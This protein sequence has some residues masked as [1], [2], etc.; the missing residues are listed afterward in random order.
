MDKDALFRPRVDEDD[1]EIP[2]VGTVRVRGLTRHEVLAAQQGRLG[3]TMAAERAMLALGMLDP[4][5]TEDEV[6]RWQRACPA[7]EMEP[8]TRKI[9][10]LSGMLDGSPKS[11]LR[12]DGDGPGA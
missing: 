9:Q 3:D 5:L 4:K 11:G 1:V 12:G 10:E 7:G 8:V 6:A 2:G